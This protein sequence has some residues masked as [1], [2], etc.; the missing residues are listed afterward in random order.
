MAYYAPPGGSWTAGFARGLMPMLGAVPQARI[1][2]IVHPAVTAATAMRARRS[3]QMTGM[4]ILPSTNVRYIR[5]V[6][7]AGFALRAWRAAHPQTELELQGLGGKGAKPPAVHPA[8]LGP[9]GMMI[10]RRQSGFYMGPGG[11]GQGPFAL[12]PGFGVPLTSRLSGLGVETGPAAVCTTWGL[13]T[14]ST[15]VADLVC[16]EWGAAPVQPSGL[17]PIDVTPTVA[18]SAPSAAAAG[19]AAAAARAAAARAAAKPSFMTQSTLGIP[20]AY[21]VLGGLG[22]VALT[23]L[24]ARRRN[25]RRRYARR[26]R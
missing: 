25:P 23:T 11:G 19:Q 15:N 22:I 4:G 5:A 7:P 26:R 10:L 2:R 1:V 24:R 13:P 16:T 3:V 14:D 20:N 8:M 18:A 17:P 21:L 9:G 12:P 6:I